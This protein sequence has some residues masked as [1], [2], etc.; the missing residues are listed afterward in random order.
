MAAQLNPRKQPKQARS[1]ATVEAILQAAAQV[2]VD[3]GY[4]KAS[5]NRVAKVAGVSVGSLYQY[6]PNKDAMFLALADEHAGQ[7]ISMLQEMA[8]KLLTAPIPEAVRTYIDAMLRAHLVDPALHQELTLLLPR[9]QTMHDVADLN[10]QAELPV[11]MWLDAHRDEIQVGDLDTAA[12]ILVNSVEMVTHAALVDRPHA[13]EDGTIA[14]E[15]TKMIL[16]YLLG[17]R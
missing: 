2:L 13:I 10:R 17:S 15:L 5:T 1:K 8:E 12:F 6:F 11:R 14:E 9:L 16:G 3:E 7:M 4:D